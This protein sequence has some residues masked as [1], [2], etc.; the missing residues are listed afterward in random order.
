MDH[1]ACVMLFDA[2]GRFVK[3]IAFQE[4]TGSA[5]ANLRELVGS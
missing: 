5:V 1:S 2:W 3:K 4:E